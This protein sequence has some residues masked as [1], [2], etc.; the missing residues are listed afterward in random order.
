MADPPIRVALVEDDTAT[1]EGLRWLITGTDGFHCVGAFGSVEAALEG[2]AA[3]TPD[4]LLL[5]IHLPGM[6]GSEAVP[7]LRQRYPRTQVVMLTVYAA[8]DKVFESLRN[9]ACGYILKKTPAA[10]LMEAVRDAHRGGSPMSS[11][12][13]R[14]VIDLLRRPPSPPPPDSRL[15]P[16]EVR[17]L[18]LL[19]EGYSYQGAGGRMNVSVNPVRNYVRSVYEKLQVNTRS[20]AVSKALRGRLIH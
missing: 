7:L 14:K 18:E 4:V 15:T 6:L 9:G 1:R 20:E 13:A 8:E 5:D 16:Q 11:E 10:E 2:L 17:L 12:I 19:A 3:E